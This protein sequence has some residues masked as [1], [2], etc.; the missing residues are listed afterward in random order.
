[1]W[2]TSLNPVS[3]PGGTEPEIVRL[4]GPGTPSRRR[5]QR[6][7]RG[8]AEWVVIIVAAVVFALVVRTFV[9]QA[10]FIP[11]TSMEPELAVRDRVLVDKL[12]Y[13]PAKAS[14]GD[15]VVFERPD[16]P[17]DPGG[18]TDLIKRVVG[19]PGDQLVI[20]GGKVYI[21]GVL[22]NEPYLPDGVTTAPGAG[23]PLPGTTSPA[24]RCVV[25]D[26]CKV[27]EGHL[28]VMGD[29]RSNSKDSRWPELGYVAYDDVVG[30]A[31]VRVWPPTRLAWM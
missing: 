26:P 25:D 18:I 27:P 24:P 20:N 29:N 16:D 31:F 10:F 22:L 15:V 17:D 3:D 9:L 30:R 5:R 19:L 6:R 23:T 4:A 8:V 12:T 21:N 11:S 28:F 7:W 14:R 1:V 2:A 13:S